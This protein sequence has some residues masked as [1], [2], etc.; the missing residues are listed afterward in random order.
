MSLERRENVAL[1]ERYFAVGGRSRRAFSSFTATATAATTSSA[2][3][4]ELAAEVTDHVER[5]RVTVG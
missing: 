1:P 5:Q 4:T 2:N 3:G